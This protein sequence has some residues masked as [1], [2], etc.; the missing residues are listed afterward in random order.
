MERRKSSEFLIFS[1][2]IHD[3]YHTKRNLPKF[4]QYVCAIKSV[5]PKGEA[6]T[7][8]KNTRY[9]KTTQRVSWKLSVARYK[10]D[11]IIDRPIQT[12]AAENLGK[13]NFDFPSLLLGTTLIIC[14]IDNTEA[15][16]KFYK[17]CST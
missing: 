5:I 2:R 15:Q 12:E 8:D 6:V 1:F 14:S 11:Q 17:E 16:L 7:W 3:G 4:W 9:C 13:Y 10:V